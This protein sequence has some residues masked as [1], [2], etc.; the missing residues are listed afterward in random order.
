MMGGL[1]Y[2]GRKLLKTM[3]RLLHIGEQRDDHVE[4]R[5]CVALVQQELEQAKHWQE[6]HPDVET[7]ALIS[8]LEHLLEEIRKG[9]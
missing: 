7:K 6:I 4:R 1:F 5:R 2:F 3:T 9:K 8:T